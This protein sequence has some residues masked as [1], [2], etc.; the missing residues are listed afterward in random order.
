MAAMTSCAYTLYGHIRILGIGLEI[1]CNG[2]SCEDMIIKTFAL[3]TV[4]KIPHI[5]LGCKLVPVL[6]RE[7]E[8]GH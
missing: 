8:S 5:S 1:A 7:Y 3:F 2:G 4:E 6:Y